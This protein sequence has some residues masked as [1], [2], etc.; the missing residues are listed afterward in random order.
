M[1]PTRTC[2]RSINESDIEYQKKSN[3]EHQSVQKK[4]KNQMNEEPEDSQQVQEQ[5]N[6]MNEDSRNELE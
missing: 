5:I 4:H 2:S 6:K 3:L 1:D